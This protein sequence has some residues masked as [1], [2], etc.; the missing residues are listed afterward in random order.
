M[1]KCQRR[2]AVTLESLF[3]RLYSHKRR[4]ASFKSIPFNLGYKRFKELI[5]SPC[6][7][8]GSAPSNYLIKAL[9]KR[10]VRNFPDAKYQGL[11]RIDSSIGYTNKNTV[12]CCWMCNRIKGTLPLVGILWH[13][14]KMLPK[15]TAIVAG[16]SEEAVMDDINTNMK[17]VMYG[18]NNKKGTKASR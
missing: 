18:Q 2:N 4:Q 9:E 1:A 16:Y 12:P 5:T 13:I 15:I 8:C 11:D 3:C 10:R 6:L 7:Y 17:G 14:H